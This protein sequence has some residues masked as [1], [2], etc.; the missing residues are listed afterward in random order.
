MGTGR[1]ERGDALRCRAL[2]LIKPDLQISRIRLP[3]NTDYSFLHSQ[4][5][6][7]QLLEMPE[8]RVTL[9]NLVATLATASEVFTHSL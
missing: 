9:R 3:R 4:G 6:E 1:V 2:P 7:A 5:F 8:E